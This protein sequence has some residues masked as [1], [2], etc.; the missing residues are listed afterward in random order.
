MMIAPLT[1]LQRGLRL[2]AAL[3]E[4]GEM[5]PVTIGGAT[6]ACHFTLHDDLWHHTVDQVLT[7]PPKD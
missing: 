5:W 3:I 4:M 1:D 2:P 7:V 6:I